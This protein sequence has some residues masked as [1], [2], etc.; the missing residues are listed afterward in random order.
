MELAVAAPGCSVGGKRDILLLAW[1]ACRPLYA[2]DKHMGLGAQLEAF[3]A[4][5]R[6]CLRTQL[7]L[8]QLLAPSRGGCCGLGAAGT[9]EQER[10]AQGA[11]GELPCSPRVLHPALQTGR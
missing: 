10:V 3:V 7:G 6:L 4:L 2:V 11:T 9:R 5:C 8:C 1:A